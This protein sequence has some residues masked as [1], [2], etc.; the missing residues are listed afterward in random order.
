MSMMQNHVNR[1]FSSAI[2]ERVFPEIQ[3][4]VSSMSS[5]GK[6]EIEAIMSPNRQEDR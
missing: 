3:N 4:V 2:A 6:R 1:A 5:S